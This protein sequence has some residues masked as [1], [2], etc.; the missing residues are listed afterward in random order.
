MSVSDSDMLSVSSGNPDSV[1]LVSV[2]GSDMVFCEKL[3]TTNFLLSALLF[4]TVF[5]W[6]ESKIKN[7]VRKVMKN[8]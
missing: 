2:S 4:F 6:V 1:M 3:D 8:E 5:V 7:S